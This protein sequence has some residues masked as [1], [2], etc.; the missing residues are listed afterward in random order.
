MCM[1]IY[2][3]SATYTLDAE[4]NGQYF[5]DH[6]LTAA[7]VAAARSNADRL[8]ITIIRVTEEVT[9]SIADLAPFGI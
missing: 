4:M 3:T 8:G 7:E 2:M 5:E 9:V 6:G 1:V